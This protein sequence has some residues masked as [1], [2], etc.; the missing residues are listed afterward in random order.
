MIKKVKSKK[1][2]GKIKENHT[3]ATSTK[4]M[5]K[6]EYK[7]K[8]KTFEGKDKGR[9][10]ESKSKT[11]KTSQENKFSATTL[12]FLVKA[13]RQKSPLW[14]EKNREQ[15][16]TVLRKPFVGL[17][18]NIKA[19][20]KSDTPDYHFPTYGLAR[21]KRP[22][23]KVVGGQNQYK[24]W[25]SM[26]ASRPSKSRFESNPHLFFG[27][28]PNEEAK[29]LL[30]GGLWQPS[31]HQLRLIREAINIDASPFHELFSDLNFKARFKK[32]FSMDNVS[33]RVPKV[34]SD[35]HKDIHWLKLKNFV[36]IKEISIKDFSS[37]KFSE[38]V[39][40]DFRQAL[41]LNRLLDKA[42]KLDWPPQ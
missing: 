16:E 26:I 20:L 14:L 27:L 12:D 18:E 42:I 30:A 35:T 11:Q 6:L 5:K 24:D 37:L 28:F 7:N 34:F 3:T 9:A 21:I 4:K 25:I 39:I 33:T 22:N 10:K 38:S 1:P 17:A 36:V 40:K 32:G 41:R 29:I 13:G 15:Y 19:A 8:V 2:K 23:F 31:S